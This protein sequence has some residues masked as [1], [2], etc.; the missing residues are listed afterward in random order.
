MPVVRLEH[1]VERVRRGH[2]ARA[3][4]CQARP[5]IND[6]W[7]KNAVIYYCLSVYCLSVGTFMDANGDGIGDLARLMRRLHYLLKRSDI[8]TPPRG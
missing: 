3:A 4:A 7:Y 1:D 5:A 6:L 2:A 8:E